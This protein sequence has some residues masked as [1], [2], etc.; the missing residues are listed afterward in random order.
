MQRRK[1]NQLCLACPS[2]VEDDISLWK[3]VRFEFL[4][5]RSVENSQQKM[6]FLPKNV[7]CVDIFGALGIEN[8]NI[9]S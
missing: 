2:S 9:A 8:M 3:A 4:Q 1:Q 5:D 6:F 7:C